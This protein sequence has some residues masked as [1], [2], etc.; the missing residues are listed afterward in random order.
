[1]VSWARMRTGPDGGT[2]ILKKG[3]GSRNRFNDRLKK[4]R[5]KHEMGPDNLPCSK[6]LLHLCFIPMPLSL[7]H[8][9]C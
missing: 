4:E 6:T 3:G 2:Y 8:I 9:R 5:D 1:M 7:H